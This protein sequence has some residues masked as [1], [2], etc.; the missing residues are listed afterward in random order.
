MDIGRFV[1]GMYTADDVLNTSVVEITKAALKQEPGALYDPKLGP[2]MLPSDDEPVYDQRCVTCDSVTC[3]G[4][5]GHIELAQDVILHYKECV[6][7]LRVICHSCGAHVPGTRFESALRRLPPQHIQCLVCGLY[8]PVVRCGSSVTDPAYIVT[9]DYCGASHV[10]SDVEYARSV[11][12]RVTPQTLA[13]VGPKLTHPLNLIMKRFMVLPSCCRPPNKV[14]GS[15]VHDDLTLLISY[16]VKRNLKLAAAT[17]P[18]QRAL[19]YQALKGDILCY[20]DNSKGRAVH[21]TSNKSLMGIKECISKKGGLLRQNLMG[22]RRNYTARSVVGPESTLA[23]DQVGVPLQVADTLTIEEPVTKYNIEHVRQMRATGHLK[24]LYDADGQERHVVRCGLTLHRSLRDGDVVVLNRQPTLHRNSMLGM[25]VKVLPGNTIRVNLAVTHGFNMDF[26]GDEGN[27]Y[28][29]R[30]LLARAEVATLM[31]PYTNILSDC[32]KGVEVLLVQDTVLALYVMSMWP[33]TRLEQQFVSMCCMAVGVYHHRIRTARDL[34]RLMVPEG[35]TWRRDGIAFVNG[36]LADNSGPVTKRALSGGYDSIIRTMALHHGQRAAGRFID[37]AQFVAREWLS[38]YPFS[39]GL[40]DMVVPGA[41][42]TAEA[43][44]RHHM[45]LMES[46]RDEIEVVSILESIKNTLMAIPLAPTCMSVMTSAGSKGDAFNTMQISMLLGQQYVDGMRVQRETDYGYRSLPHY[47]PVEVHSVEAKYESRGFV[48]SSFIDGLNPREAFF[49]AKCGRE[50]MIS[51]SQMTG[52]TGYA[53]RRM[54]KFSEDL[55]IAND[56]SVRDANG[57]IVQL[58]YG[59]HGMDPMMCWQDGRP[60]NFER[61]AMQI[62]QTLDMCMMIPMDMAQAA[63]SVCERLAP[64]FP[65]LVRDSVMERHARIIKQGATQFPC[66]D[67]DRWAQEVYDAYVRALC[68]PGSPVGIV[69]AQAFGARQTQSTLNIFHKAGGL[70]DTGSMR[71]GELLNLSKKSSRRLLYVHALGE[72]TLSSVKDILGNAFFRGPLQDFVVDSTDDGVY[73]FDRAALFDRRIDMCHVLNE[74]NSKHGSCC[75]IEQLSQY[76]LK[77]HRCSDAD[78]YLAGVFV[79]GAPT[80][81]N[82]NFVFNNNKWIAVVSGST[83]LY[84]L[85]VQGVDADNTTCNNVWDVYEAKGLIAAKRFLTHSMVECLGDDVHMAHIRVLVDRMTFSGLPTA[86]DR[87]TMRSCETGPISKA[88]FEESLD[89]L[90][91]SAVRGERDNNTGVGACLVAGKMLPLGTGSCRV[92]T[93][94]L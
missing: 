79:G 12:Q 93:D 38:W 92:A 53:E 3:P 71:F 90:V 37:C 8:Q 61:M 34:F 23:L 32:S 39:M 54:V 11:F 83:L 50:G 73:T 85:G 1:F 94:Y 55:R 64:L 21:V 31:S 26:D 49:H 82:V 13:T 57:N 28:L 48:R 78:G 58:L 63:Q 14:G 86:V 4:H 10:H 29:P 72:Q 80:I 52:V 24:A 44:Y 18:E 60:V 88:T 62:D 74:I 46:A 9:E 75:T 45:M 51:T 47:K 36:H 15:M 19:Y 81:C 65:P 76:V 87:Y 16:I 68:V 7:F 2:F 40:D 56:L 84:A 35:F 69:C 25:R 91:S 33:H 20:M 6:A 89:I 66:S 43:V 41:R 42:D 17:S 30:S 67:A 70:H 77:I 59:G 22:K 27:L 5:F